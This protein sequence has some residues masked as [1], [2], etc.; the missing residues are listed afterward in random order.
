MLLLTVRATELQKRRIETDLYIFA[1]GS[2]VKDC[3]R[4]GGL[5]GPYDLA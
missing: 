2:D 3:R 1:A 5:D 4:G